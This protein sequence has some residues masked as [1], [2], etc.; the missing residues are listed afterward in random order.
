M[1]L[2][3]QYVQGEGAYSL[4]LRSGAAA[5]GGT[6]LGID[7][8]CEA[9]EDFRV[10]SQRAKQIRAPMVMPSSRRCSSFTSSRMGP[11]ISCPMNASLYVP[12]PYPIKT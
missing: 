3:R 12:S 4:S 11:V 6:G 10:L 1:N 5:A 9:L 7:P 8:D 2:R